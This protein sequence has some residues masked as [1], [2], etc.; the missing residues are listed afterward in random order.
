[1]KRPFYFYE[2]MKNHFTLT[3][4]SGVDQAIW[5]PQKFCLCMRWNCP[6]LHIEKMSPALYVAY[7][8]S[9]QEQLNFLKAISVSHGKYQECRVHISKC[10]LQTDMT[11]IGTV[12]THTHT[13]KNGAL[14]WEWYISSRRKWLLPSTHSL[15]KSMRHKCITLMENYTEMYIC[16]L[17]YRA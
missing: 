5:V 3:T 4:E 2:A 14:E 12:C 10:N 8:F 11:I 16:R 15:N 6:M 1:M 13:Q 17:R 9:C 7:F